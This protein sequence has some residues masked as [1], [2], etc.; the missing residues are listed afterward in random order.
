MRIIFASAL[1][2]SNLCLSSCSSKPT[3]DRAVLN[4]YNECIAAAKQSRAE[5][6]K[7]EIA[8]KGYSSKD[9]GSNN[10]KSEY[11][12]PYLMDIT[13]YRIIN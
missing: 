6:Y 3:L 4:G 5:M 12:I 7:A 8:E 1:L 13:D 10:C 9:I 2:V 11:G